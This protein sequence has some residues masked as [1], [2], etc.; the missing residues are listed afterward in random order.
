MFLG[1]GGPETGSDAFVEVL[2]G[3][4]ADT[5]TALTPLLPL[6]R[7]GLGAGYSDPFGATYNAPAGSTVIAYRAYQGASYAT[8]IIRSD[9]YTVIVMLERIESAACVLRD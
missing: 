4:S 6:N 7:A 9:I 3:P 1:C 5:L 2:A 8:A